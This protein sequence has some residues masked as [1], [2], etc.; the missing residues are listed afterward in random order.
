MN[1][2]RNE[3]TTAAAI[4]ALEKKVQQIK[5]NDFPRALERVGRA[6]IQET[7]Q[8]HE[9]QNRTGALEASHSYAVVQPGQTITVDVHTREGIQT[10]P[11]DSP[12]NQVSLFLYTGQQYGIWVELK[13]GFAVLIQGFLKLRRD[14]TRLFHDS[15]KSKLIR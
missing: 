9:Y 11:L 4:A 14:F 13:N 8:N 1:Q 3:Q 12:A 2:R 6:I 15:V 5:L 7:K 10:M